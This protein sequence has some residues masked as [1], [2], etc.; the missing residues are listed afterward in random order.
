MGCGAITD[1]EREALL[2]TTNAHNTVLGWMHNMAMS[3]VRRGVLGYDLDS[4]SRAAL[5]KMMLEKMTALRSTCASV[6]DKLSGR[7]PLAYTQLVQILSDL[8]VLFS[9]FALIHSVGGVGAV[10]GTALVTL[11]HASISSLA[12]LLL[13]P[14]GN[15][16][17]GAN[18][19]ISINVA[20]L[21]KEVNLSSERWR[22]QCA[23]LPA[24]VRRTMFAE[25]D[26]PPFAGEGTERS[27]SS[28][29]ESGEGG[30]GGDG[31]A[32]PGREQDVVASIEGRWPVSTGGPPGPPK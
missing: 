19:G 17:W 27:G 12:K 5:L 30:R 24:A 26:P 6:P 3:G 32:E 10:A 25:Y 29:R 18:S 13:D 22:I 9:P 1:E 11:F 7:M 2:K 23:T 28:V 15:M 14:F 20:T 16:T 31:G 21:I 8:L 4:N